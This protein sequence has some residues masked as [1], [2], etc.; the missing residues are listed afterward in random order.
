MG[1]RAAVETLE[2]I[3]PRSG[4]IWDLAGASG[5]LLPHYG[6]VGDT[7]REDLSQ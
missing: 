6:H 5:G 3:V 1:Q 2:P 4:Y 7:T